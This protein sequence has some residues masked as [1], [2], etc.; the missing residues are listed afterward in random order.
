MTKL[1]AYCRADTTLTKEH[2]WPSCFL[3]RMGREYAHYSPRSGKVHGADYVVRDVCSECNNKRLTPLDSYFCELFNSQLS[4]P[5]GAQE[6]VEL[7]YDYDLLCRALLKISYNTARSA[8]SETEPFEPFIKYVLTGEDRPY[9][10]SLVVELVSPSFVRHDN[11]SVEEVRPTMYRSARGELRTKH[12]TAV[13]VR[14]VAVFS[15][16][17]HILL[18]RHPQD[19]G[20]FQMATNEF[21]AE[22]DGTM[23]LDPTKDSV[24]LRSS[25][26]DSLRSM[27][28]LLHGKRDE[29]SNFFKR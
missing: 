6:S 4:E 27:L 5:K 15:F 22:I 17:F 26:Q 23:L 25:A 24:Q 13:L 29:Y 1:C 14:V 18:T 2:V 10:L 12:G 16:F 28:P 3:D 8:G 21:L 20:A 7:K 19:R 11:G 9:G